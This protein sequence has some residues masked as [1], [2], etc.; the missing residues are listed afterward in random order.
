MNDFVKKSTAVFLNGAMLTNQLL[1]DLPPI[2]FDSME[3]VPYQTVGQNPVSGWQ[4]FSGNS[5]ISPEGAGFNGGKALLLPAN[6]EQQTKISR[7]LTWNPVEQ[8]AFIDFRIKPAADPTGSLASVFVNGTQLAFQVPDGATSGEIWVYQGSDTAGSPSPVPQQ[9]IKTVGAFEVSGVAA[10]AYLRATLRH[11]YLRNIWDLFIDG[12]LAAANLSFEGRGANL[13]T[14]DFY[15]SSIGDTLIDDLSAASTNMLFPDADKDGISDAWEIANGSNPNL[16]DRDAIKSGTGKSFLDLYLDSLW[17]QGPVNMNNGAAPSVGIPPLSILGSHQPVGA[18]KGS[19]S[20]GG[21][22]SS[23]YSVPIDLP[24]GTAGMEPKLGLN[25][26]SNGGNGIMGVGWSLGGLQRITRGPSSAVKDGAF[27]PMDFDASDRFFLD[28]ERLVCVAGTYGADGSEYRTEMDSYARITAV[29]AGPQS[30]KIET[31]A[32]LTVTL[33]ATADSRIAVTQGVLSW[34]VNRVEDT[35]GNYYSVEYSGDAGTSNQRVAAMHY[36]GNSSQ[37]LAPYCHVLFDY[38]ARQDTGAAYSTYT[39]FT[40][41]KRLSAI[42]VLTG[43]FANHSYK[44]NYGNSY[45]S[46]RS[47]VT[48]ITKF[49]TP[50]GAAAGAEPTLAV[51]LTQFHYD[52]ISEG[53]ALWKDPGTTSLPVYGVG[54]DASAAVNS[55]VVTPTT[56]DTRI[57]LSGDVARAFRLN[58]GD[59]TIYSDTRIQFEFKS[60]KQ[61][62]GAI[63]G[64]DDDAIYQTNYTSAFCRIGGT[65]TILLSSGNNFSGTAE[66]YT[67]GEG[68]KTFNLPLGLNVTGLKKY[69]VL[70]CVDNSLTDGIDNAMFKNIRIYRSGS[71]QVENVEPIHFPSLIDVPRFYDVNGND[72]GVF[73][74]DFDADGLPD[75]SDWR[76]TNYTEANGLLTPVT[77]GALYRNTGSGFAMETCMLPPVSA[78]L[79]CRSTDTNAFNYTKKHHFLGQP[80]DVNGDGKLDILASVNIQKSGSVIKN[81]YAFYSWNGTAWTNLTGWELPFQLV[82]TSTSQSNGTRRDEHFQWVD[83]NSDG[84]QDLVVYT[85]AQ[86]RLYNSVAAQ[87]LAGGGAQQQIAAGLASVAYINK[88]QERSGLGSG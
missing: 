63:I 18:V 34:G 25:Y 68:W 51:P 27:D 77:A 2:T 61:V 5:I 31:K 11:D 35:L 7:A 33:G 50:P 85:T 81:E 64:L 71:Q 84:Y 39:A 57:D 67:V 16:Y 65:G 55:T 47:F 38:E 26:S 76:A 88:G 13:E 43:N 70:M 4:L 24:K 62:S 60:D 41:D 20:V 1:A 80:M 54:L 52:G 42:R 19:L 48:S 30:W 56:D 15:G 46:G 36:T 37:S 83:L 59:I 79:S 75:L 53:E 40:S 82:G 10:T 45:Q 72:L 6:T 86:G 66:P 14:L 12:K 87:I 74:V 49:V 23:N 3:W 73:S 58:T 29:G 69:L 8:T 17:P 9:W 44:L 22:G 28:G 32:G 78:P 21:D